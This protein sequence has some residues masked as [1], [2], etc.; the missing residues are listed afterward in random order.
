LPRFA[1]SRTGC[2]WLPLL[3]LGGCATTVTVTPL[4]PGAAARCEIRA[5]VSYDGNPEYLPVALQRDSGGAHAVVFRYSYEAKYGLD[6]LPVGVQLVNPLNL[7]GFPT[8]SNTLV[9]SARLEVVR[10]ETI[11]RSYGAAAA[12][13]RSGTMFSEGETFTEMRRRGLI[14]VRDNI[15]GQVCHDQA[16]L[17][18]LDAGAADSAIHSQ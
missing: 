8:G 14:L 5:R 18:G 11:V 16:V 12:M 3:A 10:D 9:I 17:T 15:A 4:L 2:A 1:A 6:A 13:K 7:F